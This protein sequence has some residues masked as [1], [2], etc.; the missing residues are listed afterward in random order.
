MKKIEELKRIRTKA[1]S[2][3]RL[4]KTEKIFL[5]KEIKKRLSVTNEFMCLIFK[6]DMQCD[7]KLFDVIPELSLE[8]PIDIRHIFSD[9]A[10]YIDDLDGVEYVIAKKKLIDKCIK[11]LKN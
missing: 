8:R 11:K 5:L 1:E 10:W 7:C 2:R 9:T 3:K 4:F 6:W